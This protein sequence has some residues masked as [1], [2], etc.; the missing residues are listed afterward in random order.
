MC[1][2]SSMSIQECSDNEMIFICLG[3]LSLGWFLY[4]WE[5]WVLDKGCC[6][7]FVLFF[8][9]VEILE[10]SQISTFRMTLHSNTIWIF[11]KEG[12]G[13]DAWQFD[14]R[15]PPLRPQ[16]CRSQN[17]SPPPRPQYCR[18]WNRRQPS[19]IFRLLSSESSDS[20]WELA[21][22]L[23]S[24]SPTPSLPL[25]SECE[26]TRATR[27]IILYSSPPSHSNSL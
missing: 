1:Y 12:M 23:G 6:S 19:P 2:Y 10:K 3:T 24:S 16:Y 11:K 14:N 21:S 5:P 9:N 26:P 17:I 25:C 15:R 7:I 13:T 27:Y 22:D 4:V 18:S 20:T 8:G